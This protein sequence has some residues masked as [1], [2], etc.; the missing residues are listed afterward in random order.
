M[1]KQNLR[2][3]MPE[4]TAWIDNLRAGFG[5]ESVD[6]SIR[7]GMRG[8]PVFFASENGY[9]IGTPAPEYVRIGTDAR[10][11]RCEVKNGVAIEAVVEPRTKFKPCGPDDYLDWGK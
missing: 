8:E 6:S 11:R 9:T 1:S 4:V 3:K 5:K 10:G 2:D 7:R